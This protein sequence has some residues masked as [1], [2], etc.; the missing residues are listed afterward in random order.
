MYTAVNTYDPTDWYVP[1]IFTLMAILAVGLVAWGCHLVWTRT[2]FKETC[3]TALS[4]T[5][6]AEK[7][8]ACCISSAQRIPCAL[9]IYLN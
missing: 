6:K 4:K 7:G 8:Y 1:F 9:A 2:S 5:A 3:F